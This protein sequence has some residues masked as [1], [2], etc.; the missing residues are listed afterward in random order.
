VGAVHELRVVL[1]STPKVGVRIE[2]FVQVPLIGSRTEQS[3]DVLVGGESLERWHFDREHNGAIRQIFV[4]LPFFAG[5]TP[6]LSLVFRP[7]RVTIPSEL[8]PESNDRRA[9]GLGLVRL[10]CLQQ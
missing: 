2:M 9:L 10:R 7:H 8:N 6:I 5:D 1:S 4:P 3:V